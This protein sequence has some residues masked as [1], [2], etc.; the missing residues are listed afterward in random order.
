MT[1][2]EERPDDVRFLLQWVYARASAAGAGGGGGSASA[3]RGLEHELIDA[4]L[5]QLV[6][7]RDERRVLVL[8]GAEANGVV[9]ELVCPRPKQRPVFGPLV[10]LWLLAHKFDVRGGL[11]EEI[12][13]RVRVVSQ[14]GNCVPG[15]ED[16]AGLWEGFFGGDGGREGEGADLN[17]KRVMLECF[18]GRRTRGMFVGEKGE[19]GAGE[20]H[21]GFLVD[22]VVV[23][24]R[25]LRK[26]GGG[27]G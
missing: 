7:H 16:V 1:L 5:A 9:D 21:Q 25:E 22:L 11:R 27:G 6:R 18:V 20:W 4:P 2:P 17:L 3:S 8:A 14:A 19:G 12:C 13:E 26:E 24:M 15:R 10:R 23:L